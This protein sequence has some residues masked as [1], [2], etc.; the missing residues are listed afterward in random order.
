MISPTE[1][2]NRDQSSVLRR[3]SNTE[4]GNIDKRP[5]SLPVYQVQTVAIEREVQ[6]VTWASATV[7]VR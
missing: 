5:L 4:L 2:D 1:E 3:L 7:M 6:S